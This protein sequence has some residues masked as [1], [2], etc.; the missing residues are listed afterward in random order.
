MADLHDGMIQYRL[1]SASL[2]AARE[3]V[4]PT[5]DHDE[6][7]SVSERHSRRQHDSFDVM[8]SDGVHNSSTGKVL[9]TFDRSSQQTGHVTLETNSVLR[10]QLRGSAIITS[11]NLRATAM[12]GHRHIDDRQVRAS[13]YLY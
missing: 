1:T 2:P 12:H 6:S 5:P 11:D 8:V 3:M 7:Q 10:V 4:S 13:H 9:V